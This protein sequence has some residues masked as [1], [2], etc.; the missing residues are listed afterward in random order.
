MIKEKIVPNLVV[1]LF[2]ILCFQDIL[3]NK[4]TILKI[5]DESVAISLLALLIIKIL[6]CKK[7]NKESFV[8]MIN[9]M[10]LI[11]IGLIGSLL[12]EY[13]NINYSFQDILAVFKSIIAYV[14]FSNFILLDDNKWYIYK[15]NNLVRFFSIILFILSII[16]VFIPIFPYFDYR[17]GIKSQQLFFS[18]PTY[19]ASNAILFIIILNSLKNNFIK[20]NVFIYMLSFVVIMTMRTKALVFLVLYAISS[21]MM[22]R[23]KKI[24]S[25]HIIIILIISIFI[26]YNKIREQLIINDDYARNVLLKTSVDI[27]K[28]HFP[29]GSGFGTYASSVSAKNYS[30]IYYKYGIDNIYGI[31][32]GE[33][34]F[35]SDTFWPMILGQFGIIGILLFVSILFLIIRKLWIYRMKNKNYYYSGIL[36]MTYLIITSTSESSFANQYAVPYMITLATYR[37]LLL[38]S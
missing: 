10:I 5:M 14:C 12:F 6:K 11:T 22:N 37:N 33:A 31:R 24:K 4:I 26:S 32:K 35:I 3:Q 25:Y 27:A 13:Q 7:I 19:L 18:H 15:L 29:F 20:N 34:Y 36:I 17:F 2:F 30:K 28:D 21:F 23:N 9:C 38:Y 8:I 1:A 16:N